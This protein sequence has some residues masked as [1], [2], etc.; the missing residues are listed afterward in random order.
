MYGLMETG[1]PV[2]D[3]IIGGRGIGE[4]PGPGFG[5]QV[6]GNQDQKAGIGD[7]VI[8][9]KKSI[10]LVAPVIYSLALFFILIETILSARIF[11]I[12]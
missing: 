1:L 9:G 6:A 2:V 5:Y 7:V 8:G 3:I 12:L 11:A 4:E 10:H